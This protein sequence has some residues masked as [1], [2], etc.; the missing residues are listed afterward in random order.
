MSG[1][2]TQTRI[3][4]STQQAAE[5]EMRHTL[6]Y[7]RVV[8]F[9][10]FIA[11]ILLG[12]VPSVAQTIPPRFI[13]FAWSTDGAYIAAVNWAESLSQIVIFTADLEPVTTLRLTNPPEGTQS[14]DVRDLVWSPDGTRLAATVRA[15]GSRGGLG[16]FLLVWRTADWSEQLR[17]TDERLSLTSNPFV[18]WNLAGTLISNGRE[19]LNV[20]TG[21][22]IPDINLGIT[23]YWVKWHPTNPRIIFL[24]TRGSVDAVDVMTGE[25]IG[26]YPYYYSPP[27]DVS[28]DGQRLAVMSSTEDVARVVDI[29]DT[30]TFQR[31]TSIHVEGYYV[32]EADGID[33]LSDSLLSLTVGVEGGESTLIYDVTT[34]TVVDTVVTNAFNVWN[35][36]GTQFVTRRISVQGNEAQIAVF[37]GSTEGLVAQ[38]SDQPTVRSLAVT[39][40]AG[41]VTNGLLSSTGIV[42]DVA[43]NPS[44]TQVIEAFT[45]PILVGSVAF[46]VNG[47][48]TIDNTAPY[49]LSL[50]PVGTYTVSAVPYS[51]ADAQGEAGLSFTAIVQIVS[52]ELTA[53][54]SPT[55]TFTF[56]PTAT[57]TFTSTVTSTP[58]ATLTLTATETPSSMLPKDIETRQPLWRLYLN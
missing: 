52:N 44:V 27:P 2:G 13:Q 23:V 54:P 31:V 6:R 1:S 14:V 47:V 45:S 18:D 24:G 35:E 56:T 37:D 4:A 10:I 17:L 55:P 7:T 41:I 29:V 50:P 30:A 9:T 32:S 40:A 15:S 57:A 39:D 22:V 11:V 33:W 42:N 26:R 43:V 3:D 49:T 51:A 38:Y 48:R 34:E 21:Q 58:T 8:Q 12:A 19:I 46:D 36:Q 16:I 25:Y 5:D 28:P 20:D 53:T